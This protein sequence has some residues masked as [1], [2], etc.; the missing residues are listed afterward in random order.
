MLPQEIPLSTLFI[1]LLAATISFLTSS[2]NALLTNPEKT[3]AWRKEISEWNTEL[4]KAQKSEDK[5]T[6]EKLMKKQ[7]H[8]LQ[9]QTK[10]MWRSMIVTMIFFVPLLIIWQF[11][12]ATYFGRDIAYFPGVGPDLPLPL[13]SSSLIWWYLLCSLLF[14]TTF[15]HALGIM[16]VS[17]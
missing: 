12:G 1:F 7:K 11:L 3:R 14:G 6:I 15:S 13:F 17:E 16:E 8:I 9:L 10:M 4:R 5:K 2:V